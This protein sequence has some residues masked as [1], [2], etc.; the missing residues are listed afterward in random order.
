MRP[1]TGEILQNEYRHRVNQ[2]IDY[3]KS[4]SG[5]VKSNPKNLNS[6]IWQEIP[7]LDVYPRLNVS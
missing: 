6:S 1:P 2:V 4:N 3:I 5:N 7:S